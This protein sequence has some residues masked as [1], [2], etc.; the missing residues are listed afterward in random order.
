MKKLS[1]LVA[2]VAG[3]VLPLSL[4][5]AT[6]FWSGMPGGGMPFMGG[7]PYQNPFMQGGMGSSPFSMMS[8]WGGGLPMMGSGLSPWGYGMSPWSGLG[9]MP[10]SGMP[11]SSG[12]MPG[13]SPFGGYGMPLGLN[14]YTNPYAAYGYGAY[15]YMQQPGMGMGMNPMLYPRL[16]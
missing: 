6:A 5:S 15:P 7:S 16:Y 13:L 2:R 9:G 3:V 8:P 4:T 1:V 12:M 14:P 11:L 10:L